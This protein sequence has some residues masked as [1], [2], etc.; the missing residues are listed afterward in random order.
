MQLL[1]YA[2]LCLLGYLAGSILCA[3]GVCRLLNA[4]PPHL[5]GSRNPGASNVY[6]IS[7]PGPALLT[8]LGDALKGYLPIL[9]AQ[10]L[11]APPLVQTLVALSAILGHILPLYSRFRGGKGVA[12]TL[13]AGLALAPATILAMVLV[14]VIVAR[15]SRIASLA[16]LVSVVLSP[17]LAWW[18]DPEQV[19]TFLI[20]A[21]L[22]VVSH[23]DN[24]VRLARGAETGL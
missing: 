19:L 16:S 5:Y 24:L 17:L 4:P 11:G 1:F 15:R 6:R 9:L 13:G 14:W 18:L 20:I 7:G 3:Q 21:A 8:L 22:I 10:W 2:L 12:T 23:R